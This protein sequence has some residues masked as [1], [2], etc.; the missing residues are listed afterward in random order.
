MARIYWHNHPQVPTDMN[1]DSVLRL[2]A[3]GGSAIGSFVAEPGATGTR[4]APDES[5]S[6]DRHRT[7]QSSGWLVLAA[8]RETR[9]DSEQVPA[10]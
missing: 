7:S 5:G 3:A 2:G 10:P 1:V 9:G 6:G 4:S 8:I